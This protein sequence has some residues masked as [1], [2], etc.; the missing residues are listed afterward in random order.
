LKDIVADDPVISMTTKLERGFGLASHV[1][2][3]Y[4]RWINH[5]AAL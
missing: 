2:P 1:K 3:G 5:F 4:G